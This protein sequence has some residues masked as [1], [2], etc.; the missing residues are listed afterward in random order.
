[1]ESGETAR[2]GTVGRSKNNHT[3]CVVRSGETAR[4]G[5][6]GRSNPPTPFRA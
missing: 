2:F 1:V 4:L 6:V 3:V 5:P